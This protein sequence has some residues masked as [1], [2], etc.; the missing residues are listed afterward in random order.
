MKVKCLGCLSEMGGGRIALEDLQK[1]CYDR[2]CCFVAVN[3]ESTVFKILLEIP[4]H[5]EREIVNE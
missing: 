3:Y 1:K 2:G 5:V 4:L